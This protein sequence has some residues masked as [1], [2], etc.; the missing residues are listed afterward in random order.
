M[1]RTREDPGVGCE[2]DAKKWFRA[3]AAATGPTLAEAVDAVRLDTPVVPG[4]AKPAARMFRLELKVT[5]PPILGTVVFKLELSAT[6]HPVPGF[7]ECK[8]ELRAMLPPIVDLVENAT[9]LPPMLVLGVRVV[10]VTLAVV[11]AGVAG[12]TSLAGF[13]LAAGG[14]LL[15]A[16]AVA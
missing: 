7:A 13:M 2:E 9:V 10:L 16:R 3:L 4:A 14:V 15:R 11:G 6:L 5:L 8:L 1:G 12:A